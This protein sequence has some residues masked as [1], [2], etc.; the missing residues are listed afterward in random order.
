MQAFSPPTVPV[1]VKN[2]WRKMKEAETIIC[3]EF[4]PSL[5]A[6][7]VQLSSENFSIG[8]YWIKSSSSLNLNAKYESPINAETIPMTGIEKL[9]W[10]PINPAIDK[11]IGVILAY[12]ASKSLT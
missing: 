12:N 11:I 9:F 5:N 1:R 3:V 2:N 4:L 7:W 6:S 8:V 10:I